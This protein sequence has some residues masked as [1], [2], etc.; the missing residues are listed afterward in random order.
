MDKLKNC[1]MLRAITE[2][3]VGIN[4]TPSL[5]LLSGEYIEMMDKIFLPLLE[6][7]EKKTSGMP[8]LPREERSALVSFFIDLTFRLDSEK[9][10]SDSRKEE[11]TKLVERFERH[12]LSILY[13]CTSGNAKGAD[14]FLCPAYFNAFQIMMERGSAILT[15]AGRTLQEGDRRKIL[16]KKLISYFDGEEEIQKEIKARADFFSLSEN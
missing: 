6:E 2:C 8:S 16:I 14:N 11:L 1:E 5:K 13:I 7:P 15:E 10:L 12:V 3:H 4:F 9:S